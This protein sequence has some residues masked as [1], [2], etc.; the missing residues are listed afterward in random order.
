MKIKTIYYLFIGSLITI[1]SYSQNVN[2][3]VSSDITDVFPQQNIILDGLTVNI[4][5]LEILI[6]H[7]IRK[8]P[9]IKQQ[10]DLIRVQENITKSKKYEWLDYIRPLAE[11]K[12]GSTDYVYIGASQGGVV[13]GDVMTTTRYSIGARIEMS[14]FDGV[15]LSRK[16]KIEQIKVDVEKG[17]LEQIEHMIRLEIIRLYND[18][19]AFQKI[20]GDKSRYK[21][22]QAANMSMATEQFNKS[23]IPLAELARISQMNKE[24]QDEYEIAYKNFSTT[25]MLLEEMVGVKLKTLI[26]I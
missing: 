9:L 4:P 14:V 21:V 26:G 19:I 5:R 7:A 23:E 6:E 24:A 3:S 22:D 11:I 16:E 15:D 17:K 12:Y 18:I 10:N 20:L 2:R 8:A 13:S 1:S 25:W